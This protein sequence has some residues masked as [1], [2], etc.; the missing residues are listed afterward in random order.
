MGISRFTVIQY[1]C[2]KS[3]PHSHITKMYYILFPG[4][5]KRVAQHVQRK[6]HPS[7]REVQPHTNIGGPSQNPGLEYC[8]ITSGQVSFTLQCIQMDIHVFASI[9]FLLDTYTV[10]LS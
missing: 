1:S 9:I 6:R 8:W 10:Q 5:P 3:P 4:H 2:M 7:I